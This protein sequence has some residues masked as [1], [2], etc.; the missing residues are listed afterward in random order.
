MLSPFR[1]DPTVW[2]AGLGGRRGSRGGGGFFRL[3]CRSFNTPPMMEPPFS[4]RTH[5]WIETGP[6]S[7][8]PTPLWIPLACAHDRYT[9]HCQYVPSI[10]GSRYHIIEIQAASHSVRVCRCSRSN[11]R[12]Q[13]NQ[14]DLQRLQLKQEAARC[15]QPPWP[16]GVQCEH[17]VS[18]QPAGT[19]TEEQQAMT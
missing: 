9:V 2:P 13:G 14:Y 11:R 12:Y 3:S 7:N 18:M 8:P 6:G 15:L 16:T 1:K 5:T 10:P 17:A 19:M 4:S